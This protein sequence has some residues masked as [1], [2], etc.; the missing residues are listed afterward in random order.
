MRS[1]DAGEAA[2][3]PAREQRMT[4]PESVRDPGV[5]RV[6]HHASIASGSQ[7]ANRLGDRLACIGRM[8][9]DAPGVDDIEGTVLEGKVLRVGGLHAPLEP[10][11]R[12]SS[13]HE[14]DGVLGEVDAGRDRA[15]ASKPD[16]VS[17]E[18]DT[19]FEQPLS[20]C[21]VE[22]RELQNVWIELVPRS[23]DFGEVLRSALG[24]RGVLGAA[25]LLLPE[26]PDAL[27]L[28]YCWPRRGHRLGLY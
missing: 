23:F 10:F 12:Q 13:L 11:Q 16:E 24:S 28:I 9:E 8:V 18:P 19:D 25:R 2:P 22:G 6:E 26:I 1:K 21:F 15:G 14:L 5:P 4:D 20:P 27:L 17:A 3:G 7:D